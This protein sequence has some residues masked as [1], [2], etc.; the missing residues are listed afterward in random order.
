MKKET[1]LSII[2]QEACYSGSRAAIAWEA[3]V[4]L[5]KSDKRW[6]ALYYD[7]A[8]DLLLN[9]FSKIF[10]VELPRRP[11]RKKLSYVEHLEQQLVRMKENHAR[12]TNPDWIALSQRDIE[13]LEKKLAK[14][15]IEGW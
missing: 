13:D 10:G 5:D 1:F 12:I 9:D 3:A 2:Q 14:A 8:H 4:K 11:K 7:G 15:R 6:A